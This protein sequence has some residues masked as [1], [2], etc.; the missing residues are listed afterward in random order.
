MCIPA[1][2]E[3]WR[4][5][6]W[7]KVAATIVSY[8]LR[9]GDRDNMWLFVEFQAPLS[10]DRVSAE[11]W[12]DPSRNRHWPSPHPVGSTLQ[13]C[14]NPKNPSVVAWPRGI[15]FLAALH[16]LFVSPFIG[17]GIHAL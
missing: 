2:R 8:E 15:L 3:L 4:G 1:S 7:P 11:I 10:F 16:L 13:I 17:W 6:K 9:N 12:E 14:C 5:Y